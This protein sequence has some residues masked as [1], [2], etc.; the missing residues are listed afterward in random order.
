[1]CQACRGKVC[2]PAIATGSP[3]SLVVRR[4]SLQA[5]IEPRGP[6]WGYGSPRA[7]VCAGWDVFLSYPIGSL[8]RERPQKGGGI[9]RRGCESGWRANQR[10]PSGRAPAIEPGL[11]RPQPGEK[12]GSFRGVSRCAARLLVAGYLERRVLDR[13]DTDIRERCETINAG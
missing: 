3:R 8:V 6:L 11:A 13:R 2:L 12:R 7:A 9:P 1:M 10:V 4:S 5:G